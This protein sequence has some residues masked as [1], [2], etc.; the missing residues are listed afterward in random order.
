MTIKRQK[1]VETLKQALVDSGR[2]MVQSGLVV[3]TWG[4][5]SARIPGS[6]QFVITP[7]GMGYLA[8]TPDDLVVLDLRGEVVAGTRPPSSEFMLHLR[9]YQNRPEAHAVMHTHSI[10]A[11][12]HAVAGVAIPASV[13]DLAM[14]NGGGV[15]VA[16]YALPGTEE[17]A[18]NAVRTMGDSWAVLLANH[19]MVGMGRNLAETMRVCQL[20]EKSAHINL[21][22]TSLGR[23][24]VLAT[25]AVA[26]L[27]HKYLYSYSQQ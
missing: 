3:G 12:A 27:R 7:S 1:H 4:N 26:S 5:I 8:I 2:E 19:G 20:V 24:S 9:L 13:E 17:L 14:I 11:T 25:E 23:P 21:M 22:A 10:F 6:D 16:P 15:A 18:N